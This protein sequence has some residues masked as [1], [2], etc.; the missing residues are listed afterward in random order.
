MT[1]T[2]TSHSDSFDA[3]V[4]CKG[5]LRVET[6]LPHDAVVRMHGR[7]IAMI[8]VRLY[9]CSSDCLSVCP[10]VRPSIWDERAL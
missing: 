2:N 8:F 5:V 10:S 9:V 3:A 4:I 1:I 6:F 7:A